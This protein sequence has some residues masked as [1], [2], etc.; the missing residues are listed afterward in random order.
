VGNGMSSGCTAELIAQK[1][2]RFGAGDPISEMVGL[3]QEFKIF[4]LE[5]DL[6]TSFTLLDIRPSNPAE[7]PIWRDWLN[8]IRRYP[9]DRE[10]VNGH[11]RWILAYKENLETQ[12]AA[13]V[14]P[15]FITVHSRD[16]DPRVRVNTDRPMIY[17]PGNHVIVSIPAIP[18]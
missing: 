18:R 1:N 14:L 5:H 9:S 15:M 12:P 3:Q 11:D 2:K 13:G 8:F 17:V 10:N 6:Y 7:A 16:A 4:S